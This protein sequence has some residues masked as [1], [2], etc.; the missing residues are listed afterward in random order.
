MI[1][2]ICNNEVHQDVRAFI[3]LE[4]IRSER[5]YYQTRVNLNISTHVLNITKLLSPILSN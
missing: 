4:A 2:Q 1:S 3:K 5:N